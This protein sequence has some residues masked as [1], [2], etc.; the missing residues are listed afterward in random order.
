VCDARNRLQNRRQGVAARIRTIDSG[1][2]DI[3]ANIRFTAPS[4]R[5]PAHPIGRQGKS[6]PA[7]RHTWNVSAVPA[8]ADCQYLQLPQQ[9]V[10]GHKLIELAGRAQK[11]LIDLAGVAPQHSCTCM[12]RC[13]LDRTTG[14]VAFGG[15]GTWVQPTARAPR[16][17]RGY[18]RAPP[19][20][21]APV[22]VIDS[23]VFARWCSFLNAHKL[24]VNAR[25]N[26]LARSA[27][28]DFSRSTPKFAG[29]TTQSLR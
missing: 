1:R 12:H 5:C 8:S 28:T 4:F 22:R 20:E 26:C 11:H 9:M 2:A 14:S 23:S 15:K 13:A 16:E 18:R 3:A 7:L 19:G 25:M 27:R 29:A 10:L 17:K 21:R 6:A 24:Q